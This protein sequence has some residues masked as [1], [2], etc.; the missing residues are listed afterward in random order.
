MAGLT[1]TI[2]FNLGGHINHSIYWENL[3]PIGREELT[4]RTVP[5]QGSGWGWLAWDNISKSLRIIDTPNQEMLNVRADYVK[6]I[7]KIVNWKDVES[8]FLSASGKK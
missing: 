7:W 6:Q 2:K 5:I 4:K 3:A 1:Q 8:R